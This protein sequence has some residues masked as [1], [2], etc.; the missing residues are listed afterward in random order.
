MTDKSRQTAVLAQRLALECKQSLVEAAELY[1]S[2]GEWLVSD[3][4]GN[5]FDASLVMDE[6]HDCPLIELCDGESGLR[7]YRFRIEVVCEPI[8]EQ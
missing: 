7:R 2:G 5:E 8:D 3:D 4:M 6:G 1:A